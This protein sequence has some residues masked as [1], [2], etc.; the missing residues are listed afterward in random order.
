MPASCALVRRD[1]VGKAANDGRELRFEPLPPLELSS[2]CV[3][4]LLDSLWYG[5][6]AG[7]FAYWA[8]IRATDDPDNS[9]DLCD[10]GG[11]GDTS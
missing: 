2:E 6:N 4:P 9:A 7:V 5:S 10:L 8:C 3:G 11:F 1:V